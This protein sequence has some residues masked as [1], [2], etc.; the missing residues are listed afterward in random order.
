MV[1]VKLMKRLMVVIIEPAIILLFQM[2]YSLVRL[3]SNSTTVNSQLS[4]DDE[5]A[6]FGQ[7]TFVSCLQ[8]LSL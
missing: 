4:F 3:L 8:D 7:I 6:K 1:D 5:E 2:S